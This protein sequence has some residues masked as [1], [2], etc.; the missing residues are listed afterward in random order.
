MDFFNL[1]LTAVA[2]VGGGLLLL[3]VSCD[4]VSEHWSNK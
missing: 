1:A 4:L 2:C 3:V